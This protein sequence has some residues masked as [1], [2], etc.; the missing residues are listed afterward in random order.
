MLTGIVVLY[1]LSTLNAPTWTYI[2]A[3]VSVVYPVVQAL[4]KLGAWG[5]KKKSE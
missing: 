2:L 5:Q 3:S 1:I 4:I